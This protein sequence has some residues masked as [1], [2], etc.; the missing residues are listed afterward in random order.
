M[1]KLLIAAASAVLLFILPVLSSAQTPIDS[2]LQYSRFDKN[3]LLSYPPQDD[4]KV[5]AAG[6]ILEDTKEFPQNIYIITR[7]DIELGGYSTLV[8]ILKY[9]P[10]FRVSQ[11]G[12]ALYGETFLMR[13]LIGNTHAT[14]LINGMPVK[15][16]NV[17]G[18]PLGSNLP[19]RQAERIEIIMGP[20]STLY[21]SDAMAGVIN[22]V[23]PDV[24]RPVEVN[25][26][27]SLGSNGMSEV[28]T[29]LAGKLGRNKTVVHY[30]LYGTKKTVTNY[31]LNLDQFE[32]NETVQ[33]NPFYIADI[34][35]PNMPEVRDIP[36][37]SSL[38]GGRIQFGGFS[39]NSNVLY[40]KDH[41]AL[42]SHPSTVAYYD[43]GNYLSETI[44]QNSLQYKKA[45]NKQ[46][47]V[48]ANA[49]YIGYTIDNNS[50]YTGIEHP[51]GA[52]KNFIYAK[53]NDLMVEPI[54]NYRSG[55]FNVLAGARYFRS[56]GVAFQG[57]MSNP[58]DL[59]KLQTDSAGNLIVRNTTSN[60][61]SVEPSS[62]RQWYTFSSISAF[63]QVFYKHERFNAMLGMRYEIPEDLDGVANP[64]VGIVY[65][66]SDRIRLKASFSTAYQLPSPY[67][68]YN[69]YRA[70]SVF[71][72]QQ[73]GQPPVEPYVEDFSRRRAVLAAARLTNY[74]A[75]IT[76]KINAYDNVSINAFHHQL[77]N[78]IFNQKIEYDT[79]E[80]VN[81]NGYHIGYFS[82]AALSKLTGVKLS[83]F[84]KLKWLL[85]DAHAM[86]Y[87]GTEELDDRSSIDDYRSVPEY[88]FHVN[89]RFKINKNF[90][91]INARYEGRFINNTTQAG[92]ELVPFYTGASHN[93]DL[94]YNR[95]FTS[96]LGVTAKVMNVTN[97]ATKGIYTNWFTGSDFEFVPQL[98][99]WFF[100]SLNYRLH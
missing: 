74:E 21:G 57:Y 75:G 34:E 48:M 73:Q 37:A 53:S 96:N 9:I 38:L 28:S 17:A 14:I 95:N 45:I 33:Q 86:A 12:S 40:R 36:H 100:V 51:L 4:S 78:S 55:R 97:T 24:K 25:T 22:I 67:F 29:S 83:Y 8:D 27:I 1:L 82:R 98:N 64:N 16:Y 92:G 41:S 50:S 39:L 93:I 52:G 43:P 54:V 11:P 94:F 26:S 66:A 42:G 85:L 31:N 13:G 77:T 6:R 46:W 89:A 61:S 79:T 56:E 84:S 76:Y 47:S 63:T 72:E 68:T 58:Y 2:S 32:V 30:N 23:L 60:F 7:E 18:M 49:S 44:Y 62:L 3:D 71:P 69:N 80:N 5:Y 99:R 81:P 88:T 65:K 10:G 91:G 59:N 15:P 20:S 19:I 70:E 35:D 87:F 90:F